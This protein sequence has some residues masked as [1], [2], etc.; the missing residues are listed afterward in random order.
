[1][2]WMD[3]LQGALGLDD[4]AWRLGTAELRPLAEQELQREAA[5]RT[6]PSALRDG[7]RCTS[8]V[9]S[10]LFFEGA[11]ATSGKT[12]CGAKHC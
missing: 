4:D 2:P 12:V 3:A 7:V 8:G 1:M 9:Q 6:L 10:R 11:D 5:E